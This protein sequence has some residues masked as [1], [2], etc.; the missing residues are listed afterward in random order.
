MS[1]PTP[2]FVDTNAF[3]ALANEDDFGTFGMTRVPVDTGEPHD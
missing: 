3:V 1:P 2:L